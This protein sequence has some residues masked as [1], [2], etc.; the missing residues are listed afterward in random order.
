M[1][2][3]C[4][5]RYDFNP[6]ELLLDIVNIILRIT[7]EDTSRTDGYLVSMVK[8]PDFELAN[9][10]KAQ[11]VIISK[12]FADDDTVSKLAQLLD[13]VRHQHRQSLWWWWCW[14]WLCVLVCGGGG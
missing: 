6:V 5:A 1:S 3:F 2:I 10:E 11:S 8:D 13:Q 9:L 7:V 12:G 4:G 14:W